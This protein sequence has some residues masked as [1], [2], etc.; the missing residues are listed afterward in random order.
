[1]KKLISVLMFCVA[2]IMLTGCQGKS[3]TFQGRIDEL[4]DQDLLVGCNDAVNK[5]ARNSDDAYYSCRVEITEDTIIHDKD[6][7]PLTFEQLW[8]G[9][10]VRIV[11]GEKI[12]FRDYVNDSERQPLLATEVT[13]LD[14]EPQT[15]GFV[16]YITKVDGDRMLVVSS[17]GEDYSSTG[18]VSHHYA[19][20]WFTVDDPPHPV[21]VGMKV[22]LK[23]GMLLDSYP[24]QGK[25]ERMEL[26][27][28][29]KPEGA[30]LSEE[31]AIRQAMDAFELPK[32]QIVI[33]TN[34]E[35]DAESSLWMISLLSSDQT[36]AKTIEVK[37]E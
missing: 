10:S 24:Q 29:P 27:M 12:G 32:D 13:V 26:Y 11:I 4:T 37:D 1:M 3:D 34:T 15:R 33:V 23:F 30:A 31:E 19:A 14:D 22:K 20:V 8:I 18:G 28:D 7:N 17:E 16:G 25:A 35:Y 6:G 2:V 9:T 21:E 36:I 5:G